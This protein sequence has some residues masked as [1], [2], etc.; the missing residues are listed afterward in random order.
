MSSL[1]AA[2]RISAFANRYFVVWVLAFSAIAF[3]V[4]PAF[5]WIGPYIT[6]L[7]G[8]IMLGMGITLQPADFERLFERPRDVIIGALTQWIV[9]PT[10]AYLVAVVLSLPPELALGVI[11]VGAAPGGTASNVM[12]YLGNGDVALSVAITT[13]TTL[14]APIVMPAWVIFLAGEQLSVTFADLF[15]S[16]VQVVLIPVIAGFA[17]R[18]VLDRRAPSIAEASI[19]VFPVVSVVAIV[20]IVAAV[21]GLSHETIATA[22]AVAVVAVVAHNLIGLAGGNS[23]G[24]LTGMSEKR[25]RTCTFEVGLQ[26]SGLAVALATSFFSPTAAL[27][28]A[29]FSIWHNVSGPALASYFSRNDTVGSPS[30]TPVSTDD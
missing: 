2:K 15:L 20:A 7:L 21:V 1:N 18:Y 24:R 27:I 14:A 13:V 22:G 4:P 25:V 8:I 23:V 12:T 5:T 26:N 19:E 9:M 16:I 11:L 30:P 10:A 28:P 3:V 6:P 29:L 17:L